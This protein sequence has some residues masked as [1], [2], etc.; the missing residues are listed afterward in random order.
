MEWFDRD[1]RACFNLEMNKNFSGF[2]GLALAIGASNSYLSSAFADQLVLKSGEIV[3]G[4]VMKNVPDRHVDI[5]L[6]NGKTYRYKYAQ[7]ESVEIAGSEKKK[8]KEKKSE[9]GATAEAE[10]EGETENSE[11]FYQ[12]ESKV[13]EVVPRLA[14]GSATANFTAGSALSGQKT[15]GLE[16]SVALEYGLCPMFAVGGVLANQNLTQSFTSAAGT[17]IPNTKQSGLEDPVVFLHGKLP[18][19]KGLFHFG[20]DAA[21]SFSSLEVDTS[22]N[23]NAGSG[24]TTVSTF[25]EL[26]GPF[27]PGTIGAGARYD[28]IKAIESLRDSSSGTLTTGNKSGGKVLAAIGFYEVHVP[29][30]LIGVGGE[31][32]AIAKEQ[33]TGNTAVDA[34]PSHRGYSFSAYGVYE[35][36]KTIEILP[37]FTYAVVDGFNISNPDSTTS[38]KGWTGSL[39]AR[40]KF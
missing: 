6:K 33:V 21:L 34:Q 7:I 37:V 13:F 16:E 4:I 28:A 10:G 26:E 8:E 17:A 12:A 25:V 31:Y 39:A 32:D 11:R 35:L 18:F 22:G 23:Q 27:G 15:S 24:G 19:G 3:S 5:E 36:K 40:L 29:R 14:Y 30:G 1:P 9:E 38:I 20:V 2:V